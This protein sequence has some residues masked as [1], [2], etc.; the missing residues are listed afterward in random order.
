M[1]QVVAVVHPD[2]RDCRRRRR[3]RRSRRRRRSSESTHQGLPVAATP[4]RLSTT[5]WWPCR[6]IGCTSPLALVMCIRTT[7]PSATTNIG[8]SGKRWPLIVHQSPGRPSTKPGPPAD[9]VLEPAIGRRGIEAERGRR[10]VA[11]QVQVR[12]RLRR[13]PAARSPGPTEHREFE[14][15][16]STRTPRTRRGTIDLQIGSA[17]GGHRRPT[18]R[19]PRP[20]RAGR[21]PSTASSRYGRAVTQ[22]ASVRC[23]C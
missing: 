9:R 14:P 21:V 8:T 19:S 7:S 17:A 22:A 20:A 16:I 15:P 11:Q 6:C 4:L 13:S 18:G 5:A 1:R 3:C 2:A 12:G 10:P 23:R